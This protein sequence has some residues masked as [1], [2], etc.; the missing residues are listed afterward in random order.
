MN[1]EM[2]REFVALAQILNFTKAANSFNITQP[3]LSKH[4]LALEKELGGEL[5]NRQPGNIQLSEGG[6]LL[7][8]KAAQIIDIYD[9]V[10]D[11]FK[12]LN[13]RRAIRIGGHLDDSD[14]ASKLSMTATIARNRYNLNMVYCQSDKKNALESLCQSDL[15]L[16]VSYT[17]IKRIEEAGF[18]HHLFLS[19]PLVV[20]V[21]ANNPLAKREALSLGDLAQEV[22]IKFVSPK[23][24]EAFEQIE[25]LC[26]IHGFAPKVRQLSLQNDAEFFSTPLQ[27]SILLWRRTQR[28]IGFQLVTGDRAI[29]PLNDDNAKLDAFAIYKNSDEELL[30]AFFRAAEEVDCLLGKHKDGR[31]R[32]C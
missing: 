30:E 5:L 23:T 29:I 27:Q 14:I 20:I 3:A 6:R 19:T 7:F 8:E 26:Q 28:D 32:G 11:G 17:T 1:I 21:N 12:E 24:S 4:I 22:F 16:C 31:E 25:E 9:E 10:V 2:L 15:D 13:A 18:A